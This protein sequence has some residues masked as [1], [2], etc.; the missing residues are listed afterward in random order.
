MISFGVLWNEE[1][2]MKAHCCIGLA[3]TNLR[4]IAAAVVSA[5]ALLGGC[6]PDHYPVTGKDDGDPGWRGTQ[7]ETAKLPSP[8]SPTRSTGAL[9]V[10]HLP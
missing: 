3:Q 10:P 8:A 6:V 5:A 9:G 7:S 1:L 2:D 4:S